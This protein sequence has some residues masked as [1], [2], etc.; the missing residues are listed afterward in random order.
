MTERLNHKLDT[1]KLKTIKDIK[2]VFD[3]MGL[4]ASMGED[5]E[6]YEVAKE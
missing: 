1:S 4:I 3:T 5:D 6:R 2:N